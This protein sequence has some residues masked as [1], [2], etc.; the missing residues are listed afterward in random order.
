[1]TIVDITYTTN[2]GERQGRR[3][4]YDNHT[5]KTWW[6]DPVPAFA[7]PALTGAVTEY[8]ETRK[9]PAP[10]PVKAKAK[11]KRLLHG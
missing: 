9:D 4:M 11:K 3:K 7:N 6:E 5:G 2:I 10:E 8:L 1:M